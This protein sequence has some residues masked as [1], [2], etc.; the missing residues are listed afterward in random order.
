MRRRLARTLGAGLPRP[1]PRAAAAGPRRG[2]CSGRSCSSSFAEL[3]L[4]PP[5]LAALEEL[6][7]QEPTEV[8]RAAVPAILGGSDVLIASETGSGKTLAYLLPIVHALKAEE[9]AAA[10]QGR[11]VGARLSR[12]R[13]VVVVPSREVGRQVRPQTTRLPFPCC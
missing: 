9:A 5:L 3:E 8:Q 12:P 6:E 13:A 10:S 2:L 11:S 1:R 4:S 7:L